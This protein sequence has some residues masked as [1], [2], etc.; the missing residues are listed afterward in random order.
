MDDGILWIGKAAYPLRNIARAETVEIHWRKGSAVMR[1]LVHCMLIAALAAAAYV[2]KDD[3]RLDGISHSE[4]TRLV[5][6][7]VLGLLC[8]RTLF[9]LPVLFARKHWA[10]LL[11][12]SGSAQAAVVNP[13][14]RKID[15]LVNDV[16]AAI[17]NPKQKFEQHLTTFSFAGATIGAGA[18]IGQSGGRNKVTI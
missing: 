9:L 18:N 7:V 13:D 15:G 3:V 2:V 4:M 16:V 17:Q 14:R 1:W 5:G 8:L 10:M 11:D 6:Y 12:T